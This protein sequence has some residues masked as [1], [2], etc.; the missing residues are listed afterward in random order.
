MIYQQSIDFYGFT[1]SFEL[2]AASSQLFLCFYF[3]GL[4]G[5][6]TPSIVALFSVVY[7]GCRVDKQMQKQIPAE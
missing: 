5:T 7:L 1:V 4:D 2:L 3:M 6:T